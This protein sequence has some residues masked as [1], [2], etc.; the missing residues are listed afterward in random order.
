MKEEAER[1]AE[2]MAADPKKK[3]NK[4]GE[5]VVDK[6]GRLT[7]HQQFTDKGGNFNLEAMEAAAENA[8]RDENEVEDVD[9]DEDLFLEDDDLDDLDFD[10]DDEDD[11]DDD[12]EPDI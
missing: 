12:D 10:D 2:E 7:G 8:E 11:D 9:V 4:G 3:G 5:K 1:L 6:S